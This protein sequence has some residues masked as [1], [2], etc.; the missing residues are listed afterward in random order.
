MLYLSS[1]KNI[2]LT[3]NLMVV[4]AL[5]IYIFYRIIK[6]ESKSYKK[7]KA[8]SINDIV[9]YKIL[10]KFLK[11]Q[12]YKNKDVQSFTLLMVSIDHFE[13]VGKYVNK[14]EES[15]YLK[16]VAANL[17]MHLPLHGKMAQSP[18]RPNF[19]IYL[20]KV[21]DEEHINQIIKKFKLSAE[22]KVNIRDAIYIQKNVSVAYTIYPTHSEELDELLNNLK[23][24]MLQ[25]KRQ[26]GNLVMSYD[27]GLKEFHPERFEILK[28]AIKNDEMNLYYYP[29]FDPINKEIYGTEVI[30]NWDNK[31]NE[32]KTLRDLLFYAET[33]NDEYWLG[34]W[35]FEKMLEAHM[36]LFKVMDTKEYYIFMQA[37]IKQFDN[38]DIIEVVERITRKYHVEPRRVVFQI[39]NP[40]EANSSIKL[41]KNIIELERLGFK[42][43]I[44]VNKIENRLKA[45]INEYL[46][47]FIKINQNLILSEKT[48]TIDLENYARDNNVDIIVTDIKSIEDSNS[49]A[50]RVTYLQGE[51][52]GFPCIKEELL[53]LVTKYRRSL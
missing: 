18:D 27:K 45:M 15:S 21:Y 3:I 39:V 9:R 52:P 34:L 5:L 50:D 23:L 4:F 6:K 47:S 41:M 49:F 30:V 53:T 22:K 33:S 10:Y 14:E 44:E 32:I 16:K 7:R 38:D 48:D 35:V 11:F 24:T 17:R 20:P 29:I 40:I 25:V 28:N 2:I 13:T 8:L 42:F 12:I 51:L 31:T 37:S 1:T 36:N 26:N 19:I 46:V 43:C